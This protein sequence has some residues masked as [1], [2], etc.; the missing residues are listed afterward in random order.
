MNRAIVM[1][2]GGPISWKA[3]QQQR[4]S[5]SLCKAEMRAT[6]TGSCLTVNTLNMISPLSSLGYLIHDNQTVTPLY[7]NNKGCIK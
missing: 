3:E 6:N 4:T 1:H 5:L 7:S 2:S